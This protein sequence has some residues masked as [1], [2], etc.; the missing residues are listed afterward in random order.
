[1][2]SINNVN[3]DQEKIRK[4]GVGIIEEFSRELASIEETDQ[5]HY[6]VDMNSVTRPDGKPVKKDFRKKME[7]LA[8]KWED[9][10]VCV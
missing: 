8:P 3:V 7:K 9:G 6:V 1:M 4:Q 2:P 10:Y 5:T